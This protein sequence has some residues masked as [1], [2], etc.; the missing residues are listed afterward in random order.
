[1]GIFLTSLEHYSSGQGDYS[2]LEPLG[3]CYCKVA[4]LVLGFTLEQDCMTKEAFSV[5]RSPPTPFQSSCHVSIPTDHALGAYFK[6]CVLLAIQ[7]IMVA[8]AGRNTIASQS[9]VC[10]SLLS[11]LQHHILIFQ[12]DI[13]ISI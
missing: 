1:M 6:L 12:L 11:E 8:S 10:L 7:F 3:A 2:P 13:S 4:A 5:P 9:L